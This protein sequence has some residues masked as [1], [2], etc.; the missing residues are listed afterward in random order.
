MKK[1]TVL[2]HEALRWAS[3][4]LQHHGR[5]EKAAEILLLHHTGMD[6]SGLLASLRDPLDAQKKEAFMKD[7][8]NHAETGIPV[9]HLTG[10]EE[11]YGRNFSV[12][13]SVLIPRQE[14]EELVYHLIEKIK[15]V[16]GETPLQLADLGTGS[17]II[18][19]SLKRE[20]PQLN[21][22]ASDISE[23]ALA[24]ARQ[25]ARRLEADVTFLHGDFLQPFIDSGKK[26]D[27][28]VSNPPYIAEEERE[29]LSVTVK[30]FDPEL[31]LF[32]EEEGLAAYRTILEQTEAVAKPGTWLALEIGSGQGKQ[33]TALIH[34]FF[35][36]AEIEL[37]KDINGRD[38]MVFASL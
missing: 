15:K 22:F 37:M 33:L 5:E 12:S 9:Q 30:N 16:K 26:L 28:I 27:I 10:K 20:L 36:S 21:V 23:E 19:I 38:R 7:I 25:N 32:A 31:A 29:S 1:E 24:I 4:F 2:I 13:K 34:Q 17:G 3:L 6:K 35:P 11:F 8:K 18:A 14:T